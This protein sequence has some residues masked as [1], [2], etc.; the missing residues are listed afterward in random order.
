MPDSNPFEVGLGK[1]IALDRND[2]FIGKQALLYMSKQGPKRWLVGV[3]FD[4]TPVHLNEHPWPVK[5][6]G[7]LAGT[8]RAVCYSPR[9]GENIGLA[10]LNTRHIAPGTELN[11]EGEAGAYRGEVV[12]LPLVPPGKPLLKV[13]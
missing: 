8:V 4:G 12:S 11:I 5:V 1:W 9:R 13:E 6:E 7:R 2:N 10:L 3:A